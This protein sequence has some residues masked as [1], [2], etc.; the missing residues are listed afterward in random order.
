MT[1]NTNDFSLFG[2]IEIQEAAKLLTAYCEDKN[3]LGDGVKVEFNPN[4]GNVF[5]V[6]ENY[7]VA[8]MNDGKLEKWYSCP[9]CGFEG[10]INEMKEHNP[11]NTGCTEY[12][13]QIKAIDDPAE[14]EVN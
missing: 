4:S 13:I 9:H 11:E 14:E 7:D 1:E 6:D 3:I 5:L 8:M 10:F 12:L 2:F